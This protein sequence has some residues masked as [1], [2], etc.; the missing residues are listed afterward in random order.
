MIYIKG[1]QF[2][3][4]VCLTLVLVGCS[5][6]EEA[7]PF[8]Q[9]TFTSDKETVKVDEVFIL[10]AEVTY[11]NRDISEGTI[12]EFEFIENGMSLGTVN[13]NYVGEG[14]YELEMKLLS[15]GEHIIIAHVS[16]EEIYQTD[17]ITFNVE[18]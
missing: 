1:Y 8:L 16:Y 9:L 7:T 12:V 5:N 3:L 2:L 13:P 17:F 10:T 6:K 18:E 11:G 14:V 15:T 4:Y